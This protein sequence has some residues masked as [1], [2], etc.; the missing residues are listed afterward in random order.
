LNRSSRNERTCGVQKSSTRKTIMNLDVV[1]FPAL[2]MADDGWVA[3]LENK[4]RLCIWRPVAISKYRKHRILL[5][6]SKNQGWEI[7][8]I[9]PEGNGLSR[10]VSRLLNSRIP[11]AITIHPIEGSPLQAI[12]T[13]LSAAIDA[14]DDIL[15]QFTDKA[16]LKGAIQKPDSFQHLVRALRAKQAI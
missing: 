16:D 7:E 15:T 13:V 6:D 14:D 12:R 10:S 9:T 4:Q 3:Y 5:Y 8:S 11:V 1:A 2:V